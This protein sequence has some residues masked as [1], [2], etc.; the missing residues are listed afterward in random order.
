MNKILLS[1]LTIALVS[2]V[3][4]GAT[5]AYFSDTETSTGNTFTAGTLDLKLSDANEDWS[6]GVTSTW[7]SPSNWAPGQEVKTS[8]FLKNTGT[9]P[10]EAVYA[11]WKNLVDPNG[12]A[13][14]IEVTWLSDSTG[15]ATNNIGPF[16]TRYDA[17][18]N[19]GNN[20][21][22]LSLTEL[23][24]GVG[25]VN[26]PAPNQARFYADADES[27]VTPVL[28]ANGSGTFEIKLGYKFMESAGNDLQGKSA[29]FDLALQAAQHH[30]TP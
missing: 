30:Y 17:I 29:S 24:H 27:Y 20:D 10:A 12:M 21:G 28:P 4:V 3:A 8:I 22:K 2:V 6:N 7:V 25:S 9:I 26:T 19:G 11:N 5:R 1:L 23:V 13:N 16:R 15:I 14:Y 18:A